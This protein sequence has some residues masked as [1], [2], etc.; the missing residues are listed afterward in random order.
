LESADSS[1][2]P[3]GNHIIILGM[4]AYPEPEDPIVHI[5]AQR[6]VMQADTHGAISTDMLEVQGRMSGIGLQQIE[7]LIRELLDVLR[8]SVI[9][10]PKAWR[11]VVRQRGRDRPARWSASASSAK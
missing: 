9:A 4:R 1:N 10:A 6:A 11:C 2:C 7:A 8:Q 3:L 5:D